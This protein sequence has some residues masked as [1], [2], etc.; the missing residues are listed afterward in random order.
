LL[1][2]LS[3]KGELDLVIV[4]LDI[5]KP[6]NIRA[7]PQIT[8]SIASNSRPA[9][10]GNVGN[11][12]WPDQNQAQEFSA[13]GTNR[14]W[15]NLQSYPNLMELLNGSTLSCVAQEPQDE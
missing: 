9:G 11:P 10:L 2:Y 5:T 12:F 1:I 13:L 3:I 15:S 6:L 7:E 14:E 8:T 4:E